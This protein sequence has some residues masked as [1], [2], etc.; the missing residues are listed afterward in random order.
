MKTLFY[1]MNK[2]D[3]FSREERRN[4]KDRKKERKQNRTRTMVNYHT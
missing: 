1:S 4:K 2:L 3:I